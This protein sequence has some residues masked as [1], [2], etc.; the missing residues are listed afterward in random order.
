MHTH[1]RHT[2]TQREREIIKNEIVTGETTSWKLVK[3]EHKNTM[4]LALHV[5]L[6]LKHNGN[7]FNRDH[8]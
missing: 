8:K 5:F 6:S 4:P 3:K 1:S 7:E 2:H